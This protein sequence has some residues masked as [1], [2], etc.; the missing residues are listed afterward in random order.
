MSIAIQKT[1]SMM[2]KDLEVIQSTPILVQ[3][4][5]PIEEGRSII[6]INQQYSW[7]GIGH[8]VRRHCREQKTVK[9]ILEALEEL[10]RHVSVYVRK[11]KR[12]PSLEETLQLILDFLEEHKDVLD[13]IK[14]VVQNRLKNTIE[15]DDEIRIIDKR[16]YVDFIINTYKD[17]D[18][19]ISAIILKVLK[20]KYEGKVPETRRSIEILFSLSNLIAIG[21]ACIE[22]NIGHPRILEITGVLNMILSTIIIRDLIVLEM[23]NELDET[24]TNQLLDEEKELYEEINNLLLDPDSVLP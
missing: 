12:I 7:R 3:L 24:M 19:V 20:K 5:L 6:L 16:R 11:K 14:E 17:A 10:P 8:R 23:I 9:E 18:R 1:I 2:P 21:L 4:K 15:I 13:Y 22:L